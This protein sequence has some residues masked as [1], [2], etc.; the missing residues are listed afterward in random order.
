MQ[1]VWYMHTMEYYSAIRKQDILSFATTWTDLYG[2]RISEVS[3]R[4]NKYGMVS[5]ICGI[6]KSELV[7]TVSRM[8]VPRDCG[9]GIAELLFKVRIYN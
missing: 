6:Q 5:L 1:K 9:E 2:I 4:K 3:Q 8:T 7:R